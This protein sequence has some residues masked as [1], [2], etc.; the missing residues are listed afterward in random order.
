MTDQTARCA[1]CGQSFATHETRYL[2]VK[3]IDEPPDTVI[4][5]LHA[6]CDNERAALKMPL[7]KRDKL[8]P[9]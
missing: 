4:H 5:A 1:H 6:R 2:T 7:M 8:T 3:R 9:V